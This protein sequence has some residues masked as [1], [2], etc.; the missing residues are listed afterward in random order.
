MAIYNGK[1]PVS[2][3]K[4]VSDISKISC[5]IG[6][7]LPETFICQQ[8]EVFYLGVPLRIIENLL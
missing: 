6:Y 8:R 1:L 3:T 5:C 4:R 7:R 2:I